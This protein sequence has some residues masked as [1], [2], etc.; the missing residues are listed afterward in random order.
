MQGMSYESEI[1][2]YEEEPKKI[3]LV[4]VPSMMCKISYFCI[5]N[6]KRLAIKIYFIQIRV[7]R[8]QMV[9]SLDFIENLLYV[10]KLCYVSY[11]Y[12]LVIL[13]LIT[14]CCVL[15]LLAYLSL[16]KKEVIKVLVF[17]NTVFVDA[18]CYISVFVSFHMDFLHKM[19]YKCLSWWSRLWIVFILCTLG[20][21][22]TNSNAHI[23]LNQEKIKTWLA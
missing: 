7:Q 15:L 4:F 2:K 12:L 1:E 3:S 22:T 10:F 8:Y 6:V 14:W 18:V 20:I 9:V 23:Q 16:D 13:L 17:A 21:V 11:S 5:L 19:N